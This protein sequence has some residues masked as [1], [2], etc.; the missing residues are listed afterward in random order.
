M[1]RH[2][3]PLP[4]VKPGIGR[5]LECGR[6]GAPVAPVRTKKLPTGCDTFPS[7]LS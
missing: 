5:T 7:R 3:I 2:D 4:I 6:T 1:N